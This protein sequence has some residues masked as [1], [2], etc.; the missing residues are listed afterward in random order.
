MSSSS[1]SFGPPRRTVHQPVLLREVLQHLAPRPEQTIVDGTVGAGGHATHILNLI[2]PTGTLFGLDRDTD[3][4]ARAGAVIR[5]KPQA[6]NCHLVQ[7]SYSELRNVLDQFHVD[8]VDGILLDLG[9][10]SDQLADEGRGFGFASTGLDMRFDPTTGQPASELLATASED[11]LER[12]FREYGEESHSRRIAA[13]IVRRR[14]QRPIATAAELAE[15][16]ARLR[17]SRSRSRSQAPA[18][19]RSSAAQ[20][21]QALRIAANDELRHLETMLHRVFGE[22]LRAGGRAVVISFHSLEDRLVKTAFRDKDQWENL[23]SKPVTATTV[24]KKMNPRSRA[25]KL[26][27]AVWKGPAAPA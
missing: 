5:A 18:W 13:E 7:A 4:L 8:T 14:M 23:T 20:V 25:A 24:E 16:V 15:L 11:E 6:A 3:M 27:A 1:A 9:L 2:G 22:T 10:S 17:L 26:R 19:E 21:F 12:I